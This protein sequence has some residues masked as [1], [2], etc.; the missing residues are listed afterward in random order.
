M[1]HARQLALARAAQTRYV[2]LQE[3]QNAGAAGHRRRRVGGDR[4]RL[5]GSA[6]AVQRRRRDRD[7]LSRHP[8]RL[9]RLE[10]RRLR[11]LGP[12]RL[13][14]RAGRRQPPALHRCAVERRRAGLARRPAA[15]RPRLLRRARP[16]RALHRRRPVHPRAAH[17]RRRE[18]LVA[19]R[20]LVR[21]DIRRRAPHHRLAARR[22]RQRRTARL[23]SQSTIATASGISHHALTPTAART[24]VAPIASSD[25]GG[26]APVVADDEVPPE[27]AERADVSHASASRAGV[28]VRDGCERAAT[29]TNAR[30]AGSAASVAGP[31]LRRRLRSTRRSRTS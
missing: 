17:R 18:D 28:S 23:D 20:V 2:A 24:A 29:S 14:L 31:V 15:G 13:R 26:G 3:Q 10:S 6:V 12:R 5:G 21:A 8:V 22:S 16:R 4:R 9:G 25:A 27:V 11:L 30:T 19:E 1:Q 7:A